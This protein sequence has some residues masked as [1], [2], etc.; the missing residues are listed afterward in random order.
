MRWEFG[1]AHRPAVYRK[2]AERLLAE[3]GPIW[4]SFLRGKR[5]WR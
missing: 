5:S 4:N 2:D 1:H 3:L